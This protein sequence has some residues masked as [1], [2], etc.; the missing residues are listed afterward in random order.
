M[1]V[2]QVGK[3]PQPLAGALAAKYATLQL[4]DDACRSAF[5]A[6][7][8]PSVTAIVEAGP[9]GVDADLMNALTNLGA[10]VL[11]HDGYESVDIDTAPD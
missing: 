10:V 1:S 4:P 5:L 6:Q 7:H 9:P 2:L 11:A 3:I 8:G